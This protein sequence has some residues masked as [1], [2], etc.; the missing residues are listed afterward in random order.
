MQ[1]INVM[2]IM[3]SNTLQ[4]GEKDK[5]QQNKDCVSLSQHEKNSVDSL[6]LF[7]LFYH[8]DLGQGKISFI[9]WFGDIYCKTQILTP[10]VNSH[11]WWRNKITL[12]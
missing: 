6:S 7:S 8:L 10:N 4:T 9:L 3:E 12:Q 1:Q 5:L 2:R 11:L